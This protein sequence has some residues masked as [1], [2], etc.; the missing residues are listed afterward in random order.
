MD[1]SKAPRPLPAR[2]FETQAVPRLSPAFCGYFPLLHLRCPFLRALTLYAAIMT[3]AL[4]IV[5]NSIAWGQAAA[6]VD[7]LPLVDF[8]PQSQLIVPQTLLTHAKYPVIDIHSHFFVRL[9]HEASARD[10][11]MRVMDRNHIAMSISLDGM[12]GDRLEEHQAFLERVSPNRFAIFANL[13]FQGKAKPGDWQQWPCN[14]E[15]FVRDSCERMK[16]AAKQGVCGLKVFK[17]LGLEYRGVDGKLLTIDD[18]RF[19]PIWKLCGELGW[20]VII[21]TADPAAFFLPTD[22]TNERYEEL[23]RRPEWSFAGGDFPSRRELLDQL[24]TVVERHPETN[25]IAAHV[26][27][28]AEELSQVNQWLEKYPNLYV[29]I[30]SRISE[31]GRQ[32]YTAR[33]FFVKHADR[34]LFGTDGPWPEKRLSAYW[35]FLETEDEYFPYSEK[36]VPPQGLWQIYGIHLPDD[37]LKKVYYEN[38]I[39][40]VPS[41][42]TQWEAAAKSLTGT[43]P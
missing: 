40:L 13:D 4:G 14:R 5:G 8:R 36:E 10:D 32:P 16:E 31:L 24:L 12:L 3:L 39:K 9:R 35:R 29:E 34:I 41:L 21:H 30:A 2:H 23:S 27:N 15:D 1:S 7:K 42:K 11:Y 38:A 19:D 33:K 17:G 28:Y 43:S 37:V 26:A 22:P 6:T 25:F 18:P 20:P